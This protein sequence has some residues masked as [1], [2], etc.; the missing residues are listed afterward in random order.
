MSARG[1]DIDFRWRAFAAAR[2]GVGGQ[3]GARLQRRSAESPGDL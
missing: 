1:G 2:R 3:L